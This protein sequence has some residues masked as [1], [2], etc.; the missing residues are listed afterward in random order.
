MTPSPESATNSPAPRILVRA[1]NWLG[2]SVMMMPAVQRL[3]EL[4]PPP[5]YLTLLCP[6]K[7]YDL[8]WHNA[9]V[10][11]VLTFDDTADIRALRAR[12]FD[13][14]VIFPN[15]LRSAWE[16]WRA[17]I[18]RRIGFTGH[19]RRFLLTD[20]IQ[21]PCG[22]CPTLKTLEIEGTKFCVKHF[23]PMRH[24]VRHH[25]DLVGHLGANAQPA[26][27]KIWVDLAVQRAMSQI[28]EGDLRPLIGISAGAEYGPA[29]RWP[30]ARFANVA[31]Q[32]LEK[33]ECRFA[34]LGT[35]GDSEIAAAIESRL[36]PLRDDPKLVV[37]L[38]GKTTLMELC[39]ILRC[40]RVLLTNDTGTMHLAAALGLPLVAIFG[41]TSPELTGP[42]SD[43][44]VVIR[45]PV[46][47]SPC[48]L[49]ECPIDFRCMTC[50][51]VDEVAGAMCRLL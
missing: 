34:L 17:G 3:R 28:L 23:E 29:K 30:W 33:K 50:V 7:L 15:S 8:W 10:D 19:A 6:A 48:F 1:T 45:H 9:F 37:N 36:R 41:S 18:R 35:A 24:Q 13:L 46:E 51:T 27:P 39:A 44:A 43:R 40:C 4:Y 5:A 22:D 14:T 2:D 32:I 16:A 26:P 11:E 20:V 31:R 38:A 25:L 49:P 47:C 12:H 21:E 42:L